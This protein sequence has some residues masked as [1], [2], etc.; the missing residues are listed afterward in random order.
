MGK[1]P[2]IEPE[3]VSSQKNQMKTGK[4]RGKRVEENIKTMDVEK[5]NNISL[6]NSV[7]DWVSS[8]FG[9]NNLENNRGKDQCLHSSLELRTVHFDSDNS[10]LF[11][12]SETMRKRK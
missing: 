9:L 8:Y 12:S 5:T 3:N 1:V 11:V 7:F 4:S 6:F 2:D 10:I